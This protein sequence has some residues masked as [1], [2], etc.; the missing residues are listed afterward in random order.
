MFLHEML[1]VTHHFGCD[2]FLTIVQL[3]NFQSGACRPDDTE[4]ILVPWRESHSCLE[5]DFR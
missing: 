2:Q 5:D 1:M 3:F 4:N